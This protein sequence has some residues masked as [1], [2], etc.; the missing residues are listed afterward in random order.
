MA[1][2]GSKR[3]ER[4]CLKDAALI[5]LILVGLLAVPSGP[6]FACSCERIRPAN[7]AFWLSEMEIVVEGV[8]VEHDPVGGGRESEKNATFQVDQVW[9][10]KLPR[11]IKLR[12]HE[13]DISCGLIP[14][15]GKPIRIATRQTTGDAYLYGLCSDLLAD[16]K[17]NSLLADYKRRTEALERTSETIG[18]PGQLDF[19]R[20]LQRNHES[21][22]ALEIYSTVLEQDPV[23]FQAM[24]GRA[25]SLG[26]MDRDSDALKQLDAARAAAPEGGTGRGAL[27]RATFEITG[28]LEPGWKD[29]SELENHGIPPR[30]GARFDLTGAN[31]DNSRLIAVDLS[32][33]SL[34]DASFLGAYLDLA[35]LGTDLPGAKYDC[36][37]V[38]PWHF[39][40][41]AAGMVNVDGTCPKP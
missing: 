1:C 12:Y 28:L 5:A 27:A 41:K 33:S 11:F 21:H 26:S 18:M 22:R 9:K 15:I 35:R 6:S 36:K 8:V 25:V 40:P 30:D 13:D 17:F 10:G 4:E 20:Y 29:W 16:P 34:R 37:T 32:A 14:P 39:D 3:A 24:I 2:S 19:A 31:F 23:N 7:A 38:F